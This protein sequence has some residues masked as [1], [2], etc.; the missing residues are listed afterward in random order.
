M[1]SE[2]VTAVTACKAAPSGGA[3]R[4]RDDQRDRRARESARG[5]RQDHRAISVQLARVT[6]GQRRYLAGT[7]TG[8]SGGIT[9]SLVQLPKLTVQPRG[10]LVVQ[11]PERKDVSAAHSIDRQPPPEPCAQGQHHGLRPGLSV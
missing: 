7:Q 4:L 11:T 9:G 8:W 1:P 6:G 5:G 2:V 10:P 3:L